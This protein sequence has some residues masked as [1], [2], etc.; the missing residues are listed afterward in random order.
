MFLDRGI[1]TSWETLRQQLSTHQVVTVALP[2][3]NG[4]ILKIRKGT[5]PAIPK[6]ST[7]RSIRSWEF[8]RRS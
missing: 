1:H 3:S 7:R 6:M 2:A 4:D 8:P 5:N